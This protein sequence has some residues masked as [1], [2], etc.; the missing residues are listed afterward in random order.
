MWQQSHISSQ[1]R[2]VEMGRNCTVGKPYWRALDGVF[3]TSAWNQPKCLDNSQLPEAWWFN[4]QMIEYGTFPHFNT[5]NSGRLCKLTVPNVLF[6][7]VSAWT[8]PHRGQTVEWRI[9]MKPV[10][11][12]ITYLSPWFQ[13]EQWNHWRS[14]RYLVK[15]EM[16]LQ[17]KHNWILPRTLYILYVCMSLCY[18][19]HECQ[20][21]HYFKRGRVLYAPKMLK[22]RPP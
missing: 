3:Y 17:K 20:G 15:A 16:T 1:W 9:G 14:R 21:R 10:Y 7:H 2:V 6:H 19:D 4:R 22:N 12:F 18:S 11:N 8:L 13:E 5:A